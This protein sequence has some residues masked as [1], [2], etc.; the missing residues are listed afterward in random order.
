LSGNEIYEELRQ[1]IDKM[2][3]GMPPTTSGVEIRI[4][5]HLFTPDEAKIALHLNIFLEP[6]ERI[7]RRI[8]QRNPSITIYDVKKTLDRLVMKGSI[9]CDEQDGVTR[10]S[11]ALFIVGMYEFQVDRMTPDFYK[12]VDEYTRNEFHSYRDL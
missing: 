7:Y 3:V 8:R 6:L 2:P 10:Y 1:Q 12:A 4:L 11:Y 9:L 5:K